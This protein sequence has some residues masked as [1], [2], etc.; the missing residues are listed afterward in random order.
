MSA[1]IDEVVPAFAADRRQNGTRHADMADVVIEATDLERIYG[2]G[3]SAVHALRGVSVSLVRGHSD[4]GPRAAALP[5]DELV[6]DT[7]QQ[8]Y[9]LTIKHLAPFLA[10][11]PAL[12][13]HRPNAPTPFASRST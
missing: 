9:A 1:T 3:D 12:S 5:G 11:R 10:K 4:H 2:E 6:R 13:P 7:D 8:T